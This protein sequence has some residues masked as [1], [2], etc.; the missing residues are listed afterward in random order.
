MVSYRKTFPNRILDMGQAA[1]T[2]SIG[3]F[4]ERDIDIWLAEEL[5][6]NPRFCRRL[7]AHLNLADM[8]VPAIRALVSVMDDHG[9]E[10]DVEALF[11][12]R[13]GEKVAV[14]VEN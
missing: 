8:V 3:W 5:R 9:R 11:T 1:T 7:L 13:E 10:T 2:C 14:L 12:N 6:T 4:A